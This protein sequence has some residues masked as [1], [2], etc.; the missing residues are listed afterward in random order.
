MVAPEME[1]FSGT[2]CRLG[3]SRRSE[4]CRSSFLSRSS[5]SVVG[6][7]TDAFV[8]RHGPGKD[9]WQ[10]ESHYSASARRRNIAQL[11]D[12]LEHLIKAA[13]DATD[14]AR[15][16]RNR[17]LAHEELRLGR[18]VT[19]LASAKF[20]DI[21]T[22]L[23]AIR[24]VLNRLEQHYLNKTVSYEDTIP[25]LGGVESFIA[26]IRKGV[27]TRRNE[28]AAKLQRYGIEGG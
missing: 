18:N 12:E 5:T 20:D 6:R 9:V 11:K 14:F 16:W 15:D 28:R 1:R 23:C 13:C 3:S 26:V 25:A 22:A 27:E 17:R 24:T 2:L 19:P 4:F 21:D 10:G 8:S 7:L